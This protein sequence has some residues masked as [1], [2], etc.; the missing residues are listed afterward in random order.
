MKMLKR[1]RFQVRKE[2]NGGTA[3]G[4]QREGFSRIWTCRGGPRWSGRL[5]WR[6]PTS[7]RRWAGRT[8]PETGPET[9]GRSSTRCW[10]CCL[11][12]VHILPLENNQSQRRHSPFSWN[13]KWNELVDLWPWPVAGVSPWTS[14]WREDSK[15]SASCTTLP[16]AAAG[17]GWSSGTPATSP[18]SFHQP[19]CSWHRT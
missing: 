18:L 17:A 6:S 8:S 13:S 19:R 5:W 4:A 10:W 16:C 14:G 15:A 11:Q 1:G 2:L 3:A 12:R 7:R 9:S